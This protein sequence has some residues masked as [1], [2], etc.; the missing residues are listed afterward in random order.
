MILNKNTSGVILLLLLLIVSILGGC[1]KDIAYLIIENQPFSDSLMK[2]SGAIYYRITSLPCSIQSHK[3][4]S[5]NDK[6][7]TDNITYKP[8][9]KDCFVNFF[10]YKNKEEPTDKKWIYFSV[11]QA[12]KVGVIYPIYNYIQLRSGVYT[13]YALSTDLS[14]SNLI[15]NVNP[16]TGLSEYKIGRAHV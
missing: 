2:D 10:I 3:K 5:F 9:D 15:P 4:Y 16:L 11:Y 12:L 8:I 14:E 1:S 6:Y 7:K 13:F